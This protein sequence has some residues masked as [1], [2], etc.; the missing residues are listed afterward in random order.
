MSDGK[1][2]NIQ[3]SIQEVIEAK[4]PARAAGMVQQLAEERK[5]RQVAE[6]K[7]QAATEDEAYD[8]VQRILDATRPVVVPSGD[9]A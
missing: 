7:V 9:D 4:P 3:L 2:F 5:V 1:H 6:I 8:R